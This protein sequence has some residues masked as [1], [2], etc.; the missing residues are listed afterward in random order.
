MPDFDALCRKALTDPSAA[1]TLREAHLRRAT[2][3]ALVLPG[4]ACRL[5][6]SALIGP[7][8]LT[9]LVEIARETG[10]AAHRHGA[11]VWMA[12]GPELPAQLLDTLAAEIPGHLRPAA[13]IGHGE[14]IVGPSADLHGVEVERVRALIRHA[15]ETELL[16]TPAAAEGVDA[17]EGVGCFEAPKTVAKAVGHAVTIWRDYR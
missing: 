12:G 9:A 17:P 4:L 5:A 16:C 15:R 13:A 2:F 8:A 3:G 11:I 7:V 14:I 10:L 6:G 1:L